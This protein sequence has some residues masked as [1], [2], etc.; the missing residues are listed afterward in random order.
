MHITIRKALLVKN[1]KYFFT[2]VRVSK[3]REVIWVVTFAES[4]H[5]PLINTD[6]LGISGSPH[7]GPADARG[8]GPNPFPLRSFF[9]GD[10]HTY[11]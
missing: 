6:F 1:V 9:V 10:T 5:Q 8:T 3:Q 2:E 11:L 7:A 4:N